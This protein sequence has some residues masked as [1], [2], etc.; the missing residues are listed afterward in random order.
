MSL[1]EQPHCTK[2]GAVLDKFTVTFG[3]YCPRCNYLISQPGGISW[4]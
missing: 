2:C 1:F 4:Y 3:N